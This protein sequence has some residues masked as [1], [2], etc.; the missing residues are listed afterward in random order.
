MC[1]QNRSVI[2]YYGFIILRHGEK[3]RYYNSTY[4]SHSQG[5]QHPSDVIS[6]V[7]EKRPIAKER[8]SSVL[9][10]LAFHG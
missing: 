9:L 8:S 5:R 4:L 10:D 7:E 1:F 3:Q 2:S 6:I